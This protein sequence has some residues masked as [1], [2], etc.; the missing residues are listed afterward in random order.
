VEI[1]SFISWE[2]HGTFPIFNYFKAFQLAIKAELYN[3]LLDHPLV[4]KGGQQG[5]CHTMTL[6]FTLKK[7]LKKAKEE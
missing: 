3:L 4:P 5:V 1:M 2:L 6:P 7:Y